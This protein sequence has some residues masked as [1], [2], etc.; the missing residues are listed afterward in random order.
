MLAS[1]WLEVCGCYNPTPVIAGPLAGLWPAP[2]YKP[3]LPKGSN[4]KRYTNKMIINP[5]YKKPKAY[6][7]R[8]MHK[9]NKEKSRKSLLDIVLE[10]DD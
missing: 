2:D 5:E 4:I 9:H 1:S 3:K 10:K 6:S 8:Q 7:K